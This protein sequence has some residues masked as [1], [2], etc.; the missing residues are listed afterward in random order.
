VRIRQNF[1]LKQIEQ[2]LA[3]QKYNILTKQ[4][5]RCGVVNFL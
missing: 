4:I 1:P 3:S 2:V 5:R